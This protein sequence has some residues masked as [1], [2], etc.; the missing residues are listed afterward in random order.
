MSGLADAPLP[1]AA[2]DVG[3]AVQYRGYPL[4][5]WAA[6]LSVPGSA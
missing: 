1:R 4:G 2:S 3:L 6:F 5:A